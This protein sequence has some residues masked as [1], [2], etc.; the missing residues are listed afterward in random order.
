MGR[1]ACHG[2]GRLHADEDQKR[3]HQKSAADT[4]HAGDEP[5]REP[6]SQH[7]K[8][9]DR[10]VGNGKKDLHDGTADAWMRTLTVLLA[11]RLAATIRG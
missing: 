3:R 9:V 1:D 11:Q 5:D 4:E 6:H 8:D 10:D 7:Q 2:H